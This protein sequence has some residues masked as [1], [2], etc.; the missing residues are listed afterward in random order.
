MLRKV[1]TLLLT[2]ALADPYP[3]KMWTRPRL[4]EIHR[5]RIDFTALLSGGCSYFLLYA[6]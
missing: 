1:R 4:G 5:G 3:V 2:C 6:V